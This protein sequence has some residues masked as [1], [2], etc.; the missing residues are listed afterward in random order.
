MDRNQK[1]AERKKLN[2]L[3]KNGWH[4]NGSTGESELKM[5]TVHN[6]SR[7]LHSTVLLGDSGDRK[8]LVCTTVVCTV[9]LLNDPSSEK[10]PVN[11]TTVLVCTGP[12]RCCFLKGD[13]FAD[14][15]TAVLC[16]N[17]KVDTL[18]ERC[19]DQRKYCTF[20]IIIIQIY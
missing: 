15:A 6:K 5:N 20:I 13:D 12:S 10:G 4:W 8:E 11:C 9:L 1:G 17:N 2:L 7:G 19:E 3:S 18:E 16:C 14:N